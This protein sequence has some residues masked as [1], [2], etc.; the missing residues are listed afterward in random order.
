VTNEPAERP[1]PPEGKE[2]RSD[3]IL[4]RQILDLLSLIREFYTTCHMVAVGQLEPSK[5]KA[6]ARVV[7]EKLRS[8]MAETLERLEE[9]ADG[10]GGQEEDA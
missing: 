7:E 6:K 3:P 1:G 2:R 4:R 10:P 8:M 5:A 9:G